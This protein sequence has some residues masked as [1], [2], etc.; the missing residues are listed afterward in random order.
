MH[1]SL[2]QSASTVSARRCRLAAIVVAVSIGGCAALE[3]KE[4]EL[5]FRP[6]R[7]AAGWYGGMPETVQELYLPVGASS[8][9]ERIHAW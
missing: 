7:E 6:T 5:L 2:F 1:L 4:R 8:S 3:M 9:G